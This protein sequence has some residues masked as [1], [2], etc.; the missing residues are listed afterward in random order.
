MFKTFLHFIRNVLLFLTSPLAFLPLDIR[1]GSI[2]PVLVHVKCMAQGET[3]LAV[4]DQLQIL[5]PEL[6]GL[7]GSWN[8]PISPP[9]L[10]EL[11][12][13]KPT[14]AFQVGRREDSG[15]LENIQ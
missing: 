7:W 15:F 5:I 6:Q 3:H 12:I 10:T 1:N 8:T 9:K 14:G 13:S 11:R 4:S 2:N